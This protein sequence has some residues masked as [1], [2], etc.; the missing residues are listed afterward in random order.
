MQA[1]VMMPGLDRRSRILA[2]AAFVILGLLLMFGSPPAHAA[3]V[4]VSW[5]D[6][7]PDDHTGFKVERKTTTNGAFAQVA[8]T[9]PTVMAYLDTTLTAGTTY[10]YRVRA[11]NTAGDSPYTPEACAV[12]PTPVVRTLTV[13]KSGTGTG[14][15][16][17]SPN[18][19]TCGGTCSATYTSGTTVSL[20]A[21]PTSGAT[22]TGW[23][24]ACTGTGGC[25][26]VL[27]ANK[28]ATATFAL[29][30]STLTVTKAGAGSGTVTSTPT[31]VTCGSD[32]TEPYANGTSVT[33][34]AAPATGSTFT[35]WSG[36][37]T[38]TGACT[39]S[40]TAARSVTATFALSTYALTVTKAGAGS[41][42]VT[43][44]PSGINCSTDCTENYNYNTS[45]TL[46]A[47]AS[48][49]STFTGWSGAGCSGTGHLH[50]EHDG[51]SERHGDVRTARPTPSP[52]PRAAPAV[53]P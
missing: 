51:G 12:A 28:S 48:T 14:T 17:S 53:A 4:T 2:L 36:A 20:S 34:T 23:S 42:T 26:V 37:C 6:A 16:D 40:M 38:G 47:A 18:G 27:D 43:S 39:V 31:G 41:G 1:R 5:S 10:C 32:C 3:Q 22:F 50:G 45:V 30:T 8:T 24:G 52:S 29:A 35:G 19:I 25:A 21:T 44:N 33:L 15:V 7:T 46:T 49:G 13:A 11:Y 9:G